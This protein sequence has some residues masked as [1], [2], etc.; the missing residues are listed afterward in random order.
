MKYFL[1]FKKRTPYGHTL[2]YP[3]NDLA[4][5]ICLCMEAKALSQKTIDK[6]KGL[7]DDYSLLIIEVRKPE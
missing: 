6:L 1:E 4:K 3:V 5:L 7:G 2:Y